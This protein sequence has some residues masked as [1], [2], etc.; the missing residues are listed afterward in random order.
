MT[1]I[2]LLIILTHEYPLYPDNE[3]QI[4]KGGIIGVAIMGALA[5]VTAQQ[6]GCI[7]LADSCTS[8]ETCCYADEHGATCDETSGVCCYLEGASCTSE[9]DC[10]GG[11]L[12]TN[13]I[14]GGINDKRLVFNVVDWTYREAMSHTRL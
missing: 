5:L 6:D 10:C 3:H 12:C 9:S 14:C 2:R 7:L 11:S 4:M 13:G 1:Q 8:D